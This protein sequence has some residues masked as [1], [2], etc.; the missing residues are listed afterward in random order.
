MRALSK[1]PFK[2]AERMCK[3]IDEGIEPMHQE[4]MRSLSQRISN[5]CVCLACA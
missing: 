1:G 3:G 4:L 5:L 2:H